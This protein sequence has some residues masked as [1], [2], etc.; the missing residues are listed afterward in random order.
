[1]ETFKIQNLR[2]LARLI[3]NPLTP[4]FKKLMEIVHVVFNEISR[5]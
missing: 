1:M 3:A 4:Q 2:Q 5:I